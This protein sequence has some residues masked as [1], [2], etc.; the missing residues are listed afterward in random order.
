MPYYLHRD[1]GSTEGPFYDR[2]SALAVQQ[3]GQMIV[4]EVTTEEREEW[5]GREADRFTSGLYK[6]VP[7]HGVLT[8]I[9]DHYAHRSTADPSLLAYTKDEEAG[10]L[11]RQTR[12]RPGKYLAEFYPDLS[13][14]ERDRW[15]GEW[16]S[17]G[18]E[19]TIARDARTIVRIYEASDCEDED[20]AHFKSCMGPNCH[21]SFDEHPTQVYGGSD[22]G[23]AYL[24]PLDN[25]LARA[26]VWPDKKIHGPIY[27]SPALRALLVSAG[28]HS[29]SF[30]GARIRAISAGSEDSYLMPYIDGGT[31]TA[32]LDDDGKFFVLGYGDA[33]TDN[34][35]GYT[36]ASGRHYCSHCE[37][38]ISADQSEDSGYCSSCEDSRQYCEICN[39]DYFGETFYFSYDRDCYACESCTEGHRDSRFDCVHCGE[40][41]YEWQYERDVQEERSDLGIAQS[42]CQDCRTADPPVLICHSCRETYEETEAGMA[43]PD[44]QISARCQHT[45][46]LLTSF[47]PEPPT[48]RSDNREIWQALRDSRRPDRASVSLMPIISLLPIINEEAYRQTYGRFYHSEEAR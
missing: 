39:E 29:G 33:E 23:V 31:K 45:A 47:C 28:Y 41:S 7:W 11:D 30:R 10:Y 36:E 20:E 27:G 18:Q 1:D 2:R 43:C 6:P 9:L 13:A 25:V 16:Q 37:A 19:L 22:L 46:D 42:L 21:A 4:L 32:E 44:C 17:S 24:G 40:T 26:V 48:P 38:R 3:D 35:T 5:R 8:G 14:S 15:I 12:V 34:T